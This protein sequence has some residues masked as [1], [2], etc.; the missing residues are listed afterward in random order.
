LKKRLSDEERLRHFKAYQSK[1]HG[2]RDRKNRRAGLCRCGKARK[3]GFTQCEQCWKRCK[4]YNREYRLGLKKQAVVAYGG[5]CVCC[6]E[7][8]FEFLE[9]HHINNDGA[10]HRR[11]NSE[12]SSLYLWLKQTEYP[13]GIVQLLCGNCH[14]AK[15]AFGYCPHDTETY[16]DTEEAA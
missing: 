12:R 10:E 6:G 9:F 8:T 4:E 13:Q 16:V 3:D 15:T 14:A 11:D 5:K 2:A 7:G 1:W